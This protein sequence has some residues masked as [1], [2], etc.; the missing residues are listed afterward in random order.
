MRQLIV[1]IGHKKGRGK[2]TLS[3]LII[4]TLQMKH[5]HLKVR[6]IGFADKLKD[7]AH[8]VYGWAGLMP[9]VWYDERYEMK[10][11]VLPD[12]GKTPRQIWIEVGNYFRQI[13]ESTWV[14]FALNGMRGDIILIKDLGFTNEAK[15]IRAKDGVLIRIQRDD[16]GQ[17]EGTDPR[18]IELDPWT[19][20]DYDVLNNGTIRDL[21]T[22]AECIAE[23]LVS[24]L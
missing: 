4:N 15:S 22:T 18:E 16:H 3:D 9:G 13:Y 20:W 12:I 23:G 11:Q 24:R 6:K 2:D 21:V 7:I 8:Q 19:D 10:E 5:G 1:G 14:D 17:S